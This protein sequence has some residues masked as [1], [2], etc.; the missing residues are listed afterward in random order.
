MTKE[1]EN[2]MIALRNYTEMTDPRSAILFA[3]AV[4]A[5]VPLLMLAAVGG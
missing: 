3:V 4:M 5:F 1:H 2:T